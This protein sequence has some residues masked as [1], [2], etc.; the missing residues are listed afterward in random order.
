M[1]AGCSIAGK[2]R[3]QKIFESGTSQND[4]L[5]R[6]LRA[7]ATLTLS[8][9]GPPRSQSRRRVCICLPS[10]FRGSDCQLERFSIFLNPS[11]FL[12]VGPFRFRPRPVLSFAGLLS[13]SDSLVSLRSPPL[14]WL[15]GLVVDLL[16]SSHVPINPP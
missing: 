9:L 12:P 15:F 16:S 7:P 6:F 10:P 14:I 13:S 8:G 11:P 4:Q 2:M 5:R 3:Y 1:V